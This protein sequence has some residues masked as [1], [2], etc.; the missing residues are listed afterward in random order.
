MSFRNF[1]LVIKQKRRNVGI[2]VLQHVFDI[3]KY[4]TIAKCLHRKND[5]ALLI[6]D[7]IRS[8]RTV[9]A[10][11][12]KIIIVHK[13]EVSEGVSIFIEERKIKILFPYRIRTVE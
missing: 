1:T 3:A 5:I 10:R 6:A 13:I 8:T 2:I 4:I 9:R 11:A 12:T 7:P